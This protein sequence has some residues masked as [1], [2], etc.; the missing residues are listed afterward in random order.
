MQT[1]HLIF[2]IQLFSTLAMVGLIWFVQVVHYPMFENV[3]ANDFGKYSEIHQAKTSFVV[4]PFMIAE[5]ATAFALL[6]IKLP[7]I[8]SWQWI[9]AAILLVIVWSSTFFVQVP[10]HAKL[11]SGYDLTTI[12]TLVNT[13]WIRTICWSIRGFMLVGMV[14]QL[15]SLKNISN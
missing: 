15:L 13:N 5:I 7:G 9:V 8:P 3:G 2:A 11:S 4:I 10:L 14:P 12:R 6:F 1:A